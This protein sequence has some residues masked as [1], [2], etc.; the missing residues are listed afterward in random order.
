MQSRND[1]AS[2]C[3]VFIRVC[4]KVDA[5]GIGLKGMRPVKSS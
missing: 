3:V 1:G 2:F 4:A 5:D